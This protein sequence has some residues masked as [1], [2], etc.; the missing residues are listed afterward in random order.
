MSKGR[1][2]RIT[3]QRE[4]YRAYIHSKDV[5]EIINKKRHALAGI[6]VMRKICNHPDLLDLA[7]SEISE[8]YGDPE[9]SGKMTIMAKVLKHWK[10][11][12]NL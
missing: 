2:F 12:V 9:R 8:D 6:D 5:I 7:K 10:E 11:E 1:Y 4:L 3:E